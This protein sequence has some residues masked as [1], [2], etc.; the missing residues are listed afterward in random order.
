[1]AKFTISK[2]E[3]YTKIQRESAIHIQYNKLLVIPQKTF[4]Y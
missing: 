3:K 2:I 4:K 1:M